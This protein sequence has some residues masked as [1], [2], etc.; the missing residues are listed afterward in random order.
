VGV[1]LSY[2]RKGLLREHKEAGT[3][4][5]FRGSSPIWPGTTPKE[6]TMQPIARKTHSLAMK[7]A[8][9]ALC[10]LALIPSAD[11][12]HP[13]DNP[14]ASK[15]GAPAAAKTTPVGTVLTVPLSDY[16][17][18]AAENGMRQ[19]QVDLLQVTQMVLGDTNTQAATIS[20][21]D[22]HNKHSAKVCWL[23]AWSLGWVQQANKNK[24][25]VE[26]T[27]I[28]PGNTQVAQV[29]VQQNNEAE[30]PTGSHFMMCPL[31]AVGAIQALNPANINVVNV[32]QLAVGDNNSQVALL[33]VDQQTASQLQVP[34]TAAGSLVQLNINLTIINQIAIGNNNTQVATVN[35]GQGST[36]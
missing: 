15:P 24:T 32:S 29:E 4:E 35:V 21:R 18:I 28:G 17:A 12:K 13:A 10:G 31:W 27:A 5:P 23:P 6:V 33:S 7:L 25:L 26:Q 9:M 8:L 14:S 34:A 20:I 2:S 36:L 19:N 3:S 16:G 1:G 11:A 30:V 22:K